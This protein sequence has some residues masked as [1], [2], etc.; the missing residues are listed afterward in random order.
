VE[1]EGSG[2][3]GLGEYG[4]VEVAGGEKRRE[5]Y[6]EDISDIRIKQEAIKLSCWVFKK[7]ECGP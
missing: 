7:I 3:Q 1:G 5:K 2:E 6:R 4:G